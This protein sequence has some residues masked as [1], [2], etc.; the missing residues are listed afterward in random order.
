M[1]HKT[2]ISWSFKDSMQRGWAPILHVT[3]LILIQDQ[4]YTH[5]I[6]MHYM[7]ATDESRIQKAVFHL[8]FLVIC[9]PYRE[10]RG[11]DL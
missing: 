7:N 1:G 5:N 4:N 6:D 11:P 3:K 10:S 9:I 8:E 2:S